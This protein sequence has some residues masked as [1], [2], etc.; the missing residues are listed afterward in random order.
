MAARNVDDLYPLSPAQ[1]G[2]LFH[3]LAA[4]ES[5]VYFEQFPLFFEGLEP[6]V[7]VAAWQRVVDRHP[8][9]RTSFLW[10]DLEA[11]VQVV[12]RKVQVP[13]ERL[14]WRGRGAAEQQRDLDA[15]AAADR[16]RGFDLTRPPLLRLALFRL[17]ETSHR[18]IWSHHHLLLD[19]WSVG[20]MMNELFKLYHAILQGD[21][22]PLPARRP[23]GDYIRWLRQRDPAAAVAAEAYWRQA[24]AGFR[25]PTLL[26]APRAS[27]DPI[28]PDYELRP[29]RLSADL[30][31][32]L[33]TFA[34]RHR[35]TLITLVYAA[36]ALYLAGASG[37]RDVLFGTTTSGRAP[38]LA[39]VDTMLGCLIH[40]L[41]VRVE[42][43]PDAQLVPWLQALQKSL[44]ELRRHEHTPL[45]DILGWT[46]VPRRQPLF[47]SLVVFESFPGEAAFTMT[48]VGLFQRMHYPLHL[49][50]SPEPVLIL[51]LGFEPGRL[52]V[53]GALQVLSELE[54]LLAAMV[55]NP[56]RRLGSLTLRGP[57]AHHRVAAERAEEET[58][59][60]RPAPIPPRTEGERAI[61]AIWRQVLG[62][63]QVGV[64]DD[65]FDLGGHSLLL[66]RMADKA[67]SALGKEL[68][69][70]RLLTCRTIAALAVAVEEGV[71]RPTLTTA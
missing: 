57:A 17:D 62:I 34:Q 63:A 22:D 52:P 38:E 54:S 13:V 30:T 15:Y 71:R 14:D 55:E 58:E 39:G 64:E 69:L 50:A 20:L 3:T 37:E 44:V 6:D 19:G 1:H 51:R 7:F 11:P 32:R 46:Q 59:S 36:W 66:L 47:D 16:R 8:I 2:I 49:V 61:A 24:L 40:T 18:V 41:P 9:L 25:R 33:K 27:S 70:G 5:G 65:F 45:L 21:P 42:V 67:R 4:P 53:E 43:D 56:E 23:Y 31:V 29:T 26:L 12:H 48:H 68:P 60:R 10:E 28:G 35:L